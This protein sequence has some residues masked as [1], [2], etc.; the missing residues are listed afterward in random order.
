[1][2]G[3]LSVAALLLTSLVGCREPTQE[4]THGFF[5]YVCVGEDDHACVGG[6]EDA[7]AGAIAVGGRFDLTYVPVGA[8]HLGPLAGVAPASTEVVD[9]LSD[10]ADGR[11]FRFRIDGEAAFLALARSGAV[12]DFTHLRSERPGSIEIAMDGA[13]I[14]SLEMVAGDRERLLAVPRGTEGRLAGTMDCDWRL[15]GESNVAITSASQGCQVVIEALGA[16]EISLEIT[17]GVGL[18][19]RM[20]VAVTAR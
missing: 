18:S 6:N 11:G 16:G 7:L 14:D 17:M 10:P 19:R 15:R 4:P 9:N 2:Y 20:R 12:I 1:M 8:S 3:R 13:F 5:V